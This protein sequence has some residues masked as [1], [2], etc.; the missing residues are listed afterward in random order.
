VIKI[1]AAFLALASWTPTLQDKA[2]LELVY[3][4]KFAENFK[5]DRAQAAQDARKLL[6]RRLER[7]SIP[8]ASVAEGEEARVKV[9]LPALD[10]EAL[11]DCKAVLSRRG[12][13]ECCEVAS[14]EIQEAFNR[15][16]TVPDGYRAVDQPEALR[17]QTED[18]YAAWN[19][20]KLLVRREPVFDSRALRKAEAR[21]ELTFA[22]KTWAL[23]LEVD[24]A[25]ARRLDDAVKDLFA[26]RPHGLLALLVDGGLRNRPA[27]RS[28]ALGGHAMV[29]GL[30]K[31]EARSLALALGGGVLLVPLELESE[32]RRDGK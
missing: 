24:A 2:G 18:D 1:A 6:V 22:S 7:L 14:K 29:S 12:L 30:D 10:P 13:V 16:G 4:L 8:G 31:A 27:V 15:D 32:R 26:R 23:E 17:K 28:E 11:F 19:G 3:R 21:E 9:L 25:A 5:G 20:P